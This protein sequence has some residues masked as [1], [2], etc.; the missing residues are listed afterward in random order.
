VESANQVR[1][2]FPIQNLPFGVFAPL[3]G[4]AA[5][6]GVAIGDQVV[7][8]A[9]CQ[10]R[11]LFSGEAAEGASAFG[12]DSLN[13]FMALGR[14]C[15][16]AVR[17]QLFQAL[18]HDA[19]PALRERVRL[20]PMDEVEMRLPTRV[21]D[22]T[23][24]YASIHHATN[25]GSMLRP[26]NPLLPNY[27]WLPVAYHGRASSLVASGTP[28]RRPRGQ[29]SETANEPPLFALSRHLDYEAEAGFFIGPGN[30][31]GEPVAIG[32]AEEH[33]FGLCLVTDW[34]A[35]DLQTWEYQPLGPFLAKNFA[36]TLSPWVVTLEALQPFRVAAAAR[37]EGDPRPLPHLFDADDQSSGGIALTVEVWLSSGQMRERGIEP[38]RL[39]CGRL[40]EMYW[41]LAQML[42]HHTSNGCNLQPGDLLASGTISGPTK[43]ER[44]CLLEL[45]WR[46]AEPITL[47][48]GEQRRFLEDGDEITLR[49]YCQREDAA[50]IGFGEC[51][52]VVLPAL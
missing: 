22:Y 2:D 1:S 48:T 20:L 12:D 5:R 17:L 18:R 19:S 43:S 23:D 41:T 16:T 28:V 21:G 46:G 15:W 32:K 25:V 14:R 6:I 33:I 27:K 30:R 7:D 8:L 40:S 26:E 29:I 44:G 11:G 37:A 10:E 31:L 36:T 49:G 34:S 39:S 3:Q 52:G 45:T 9:E 4:G 38:M 13:V 42:A 35:R 51:R 47:P 24:F 50:R